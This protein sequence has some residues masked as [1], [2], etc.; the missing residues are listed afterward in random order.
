MS[1]QKT[2]D[3]QK[4]VEN[5]EDPETVEKSYDPNEGSVSGNVVSANVASI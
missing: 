1:D 5:P 2:I 3:F 4:D